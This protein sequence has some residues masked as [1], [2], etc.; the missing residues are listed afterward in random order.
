MKTHKV[1]FPSVHP[2]GGKSFEAEA[3]AP[4]EALAIRSVL[5]AVAAQGIQLEC[6]VLADMPDL[7]GAVLDGLKLSS[8]TL[9]NVNLQGASLRGARIERS[10]FEHVHADRTT[11][12]DGAQLEVVSF[13][14]CTLNGLV[15][16]GMNAAHLQFTKS[17]ASDVDATDST[18]IGLRNYGRSSTLA[19]W[20]HDG[21]TIQS[22][23]FDPQS[24]FAA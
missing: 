20:K 2:S 8:C 10:T 16:R 12:F 22:G 4:T 6:V 23:D 24:L 15:A 7:S 9:R 13:V 21:A 3:D 11:R 19:R 18:V 5:E 14:G 17:N 1:I